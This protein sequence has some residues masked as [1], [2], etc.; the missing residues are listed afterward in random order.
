MK[1]DIVERIIEVSN[2]PPQIRRRVRIVV[3]VMSEQQFL[4]P[5]PQ[6]AGHK[7]FD[8]SKVVLTNCASHQP[9]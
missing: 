5:Q 3:R 8:K 9:P 6:G 1:S 4:S 7:N 2:Y